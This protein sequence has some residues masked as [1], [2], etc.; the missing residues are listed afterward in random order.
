MKTSQ[1]YSNVSHETNK[2]ARIRSRYLRNGKLRTETVNR[3]DD[4][5]VKINT[6][7]RDNSTRLYMA[8]DGRYMT[9]SGRQVRTLMRT[10]MEHFNESDKNLPDVK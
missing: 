9:L 1:F 2:N 5:S 8:V 3:E 4:F 6:N 10:V 7:E